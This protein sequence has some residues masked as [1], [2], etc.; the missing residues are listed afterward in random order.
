MPDGRTFAFFAGEG[1][2]VS[3]DEQDWSM[4]WPATDD[5]PML[6]M[7]VSPIGAGTLAAVTY[8]G[9]ILTSS[10][11]GLSWSAFAK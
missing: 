7:A 2:L 6:H 11:G 4:L 9:R 3:N 8:E 10:D 1:L 5:D